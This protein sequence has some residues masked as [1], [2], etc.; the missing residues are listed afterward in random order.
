MALMVYSLARIGA[1]LGMKVE[2]AYTP[3]S[4]GLPEPPD[5]FEYLP[6]TAPRDALGLDPVQHLRASI[7]IPAS[8]VRGCVVRASS[9]DK[10]RPRW[11]GYAGR[12]PQ[13]SEL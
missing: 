5:L 3:A 12:E 11:P 2:D 13:W 10:S 1:A 8:R 7:I 9:P 4:F 6:M